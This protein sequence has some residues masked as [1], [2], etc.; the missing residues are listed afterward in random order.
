MEPPT[1]R[2]LANIA[3]KGL[4]KMNANMP[5]L[6]LMWPT[7]LGIATLSPYQGVWSVHV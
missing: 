5:M 2:R 3:A 1:T 6:A 7:G 4:E